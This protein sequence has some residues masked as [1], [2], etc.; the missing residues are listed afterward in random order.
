MRAFPRSRE[1]ELVTSHRLF[2]FACSGLYACAITLT[3]QP[4]VAYSI[5]S[6]ARTDQLIKRRSKTANIA[7]IPIPIRATTTNAANTSGTLKFDPAINMTLP[8]PLLP[9]T[10]SAIT[11]P[12]KDSNIAI[13]SDAK[14]WQR[15]GETNL[16]DNVEAGGA[17][18]T[19]DVDE[20]GLNRCET[21]Y[22]IDHD[23]EKRKHE[24]GNYGW[25][26]A[27]PE[28]DDEDRH[29]GHLRYTIE[30]D[31]KGIECA[32]GEAERTDQD[33]EGQAE[34]DGNHEPSRVVIKVAAP[35]T[36]NA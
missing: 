13:L 11:E 30:S 6:P 21:C 26:R 3:F 27:D 4:P 15:S 33:T 17:E 5:P 9:A 31:Q 10:I 19:Q 1:R 34:D 22:H 32:I 18:G 8:I 2:S 16:A 28:P 36:A 12:T 14:M 20:F 25:H 35:C 24:G 23:R 29:Q 7:Y